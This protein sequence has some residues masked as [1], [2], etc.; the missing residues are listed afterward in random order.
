MKYNSGVGHMASSDIKTTLINET[1][2]LLQE[3]DNK[4]ESESIE[5]VLA[6]QG[7]VDYLEFKR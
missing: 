5:K 7:L 1:R 2:K 3:Y 4:Y 6:L